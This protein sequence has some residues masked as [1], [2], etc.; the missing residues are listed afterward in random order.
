MADGLAALDILKTMSKN[1][2]SDIFF[3]PSGIPEVSKSVLADYLKVSIG[4]T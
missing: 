1:L 4:M 2:P 3:C